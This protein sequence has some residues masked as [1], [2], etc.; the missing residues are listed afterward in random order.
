VRD[1]ARKR[2]FMNY[3]NVYFWQLK[4]IATMKGKILKDALTND[5]KYNNLNKK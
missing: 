2:K 4:K 1:I 5:I 3:Y